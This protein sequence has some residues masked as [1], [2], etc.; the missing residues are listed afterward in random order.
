MINFIICDDN[1][2]FTIL[3][4]RKIKD[5]MMKHKEIESE[6]HIFSGYGVEFERII[7]T[8]GG[9]KVYFLDIE[10]KKGSGLDATRIIREKYEDWTS[11][12]LIVTSH[13]EF[14]YE[15]L[16][17]RLDLFDF[18]NKLDNFDTHLEEDLK[19]ILKKYNQSSKCITLEF[20]RAVHKIELRDI[21][22]IEKEIDSKKCK[23]VTTY[24]ER[25]VQCSL[26]DINNKLDENFMKASRSLIVNIKK[27]K[28]YDSKTNTVYFVNEHESTLVSRENKKELLNRVKN[29]N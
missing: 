28:T 29:N 17:N 6:Y 10:T 20:D 23:I 1:K 22:F 12:I 21:I 7:R 25:F 8:E 13:E 27:I 26:N 3:L 24:G 19:N 2:D 9:F 16:G 14:R 11:I 4:R 15:A 5:F 18:L